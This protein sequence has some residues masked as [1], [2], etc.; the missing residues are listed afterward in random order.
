MNSTLA[1][2]FGWLLRAS[3]QGAVLAILVLLAQFFLRKRLDARWRHLLWLLVL[4]RL[5]MPFSPPSPASLFNYVRL[6]PRTNTGR[7]LLNQAVFQPPITA[8]TESV[9]ITP[10]PQTFEQSSPSQSSSPP[11]HLASSPAATS[12][13]RWQLPEWPVCMALIWAA[14]VA[15]LGIR[16]VGQNILFAGGL[17]ADACWT[18]RKRWKF[19]SVANP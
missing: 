1:P 9:T 10:P 3:A 5:A 2:F 18:I 16:V 12:Q 17:R 8:Q 14:G 7:P 6:E 13:H 11:P 4:A 15:V 19:S